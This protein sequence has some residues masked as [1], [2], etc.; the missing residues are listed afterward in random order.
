[1]LT[2]TGWTAVVAS[3]VLL[4]T[5]VALGWLEPATIAVAALMGIAS[6]LLWVLYRPSLQV[7]HE[8]SRLRVTVGDPAEA[9]VR[10]TNTSGRPSLPMM[11]LD[12]VGS[13]VVEVPLPRLAPKRSSSTT[14][15][16]PTHHRAVLGIGPLQLTRADPFGFVRFEQRRGEAT[17]LYVHPTRHALRGMPASLERHLDGATSDT[18]PRGSQVFHALR[19]YVPGDARRLI[20]WKTSARTGTLMVREHVDPSLPDLTVIL[21]TRRT[22]HSPESFESA[23]EVAA[24][25]LQACTSAG[26]PARL[27]TSD[28]QHYE[29]QSGA[30]RGTWFLD[31]LAAVE[32]MDRGDLVGLAQMLQSGGG[33]FALVVVSGRPSHED[34]RACSRLSRSYNSVTVADL[35]PDPAL[36]ATAPGVERIEA[37]NGIE[38]AKIWSQR[39]RW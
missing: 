10:V 34:V 3:I 35:N 1:M 31:R 26:F 9:T 16:L 32:L 37:S 15:P 20:H 19:E 14:Y 25:L 7:E 17:V 24:S 36:R 6:G 27:R 39:A 30:D 33:G 12:R 4:I 23:I 21:D 8:V 18:A 2:R 13:R 38:F 22:Q 11:G 28:G 29:P 5:S